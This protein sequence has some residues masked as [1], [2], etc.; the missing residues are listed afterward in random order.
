VPELV[1]GFDLDMTLIDS[2]PGVRATFDALNAELGMAIDGELLASRLGP[3]LEVVMAAYLPPD[4]VEPYCDRYRA[5]YAELGPPGSVLLDGAAE[6][7]RSVRARGGRTLVVTAK[8][9]ANA[10]RC[11]AAVGLADL[12]DVV[13]GWRHGPQKGETLLEHGAVAYVGDTPPDIAA[14]RVADATAIAVAT[15]PWSIEELRA[16]GADVLLESLSEFPRWL[17]AF[18]ATLTSR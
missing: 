8:Y 2:R 5:V 13:V 6:A 12:V 11:L 3:P 17:D 18:A 7:V 15:G 14:A 16:E 9:E 1:V 10:H 4:E